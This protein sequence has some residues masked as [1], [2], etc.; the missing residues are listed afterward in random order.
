M[1]FETS[2][3]S[4]QSKLEPK[5]VSAL[6][7]AKRLFWL[8]CFYFETKSF[9]VSV[10][11]KQTETT[12]QNLHLL[13]NLPLL[14]S[15]LQQPILPLGESTIKEPVLPMD[16]STCTIYSILQQPVLPFGRIC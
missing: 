2:L 11:S 7:E 5:I 3:D 15:V 4:K 6:S 8:F 16:V 9:G 14:Q 10:Q 13:P 1:S 12:G